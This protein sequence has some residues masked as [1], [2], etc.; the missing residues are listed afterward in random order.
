MYLGR[1]LPASLIVLSSFSPVAALA[2]TP[3]VAPAT[4]VVGA[5]PAPPTGSGPGTLA[6]LSLPSATTQVGHYGTAN[7]SSGNSFYVGY[8][9]ATHSIYTP[10]FAGITY[11]SNSSSLQITGSF[12]SIPGGR[13][14]RVASNRNVL[15][16]LAGNALAA[17]ALHTHKQLF[18][19]TVGG[20][21]LVTSPH[22][23]VAFVGGNMDSV[24]TAIDLRTGKILRTYNVGQVGDMVWANGQIFAADIQTGV[25]TALNPQTGAIVTI[26]TPEVDPNFSY[27]NI[28]AATAGFM[29]LAVGA[30]HTTVYAAGFSGHILRFSTT[31]DRYL[32]EVSVNA[33]P[34]STG[35]N[36]LSALAILPERNRALVTVENLGESVIVNLSTGSIMNT[37]HAFASNRWLVIPRHNR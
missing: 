6:S 36:K 3:S 17:Y 35:G 2:Q 31:R 10:A 7:T 25:M 20:N 15:L 18:M 28:P 9:R 12:P 5:F 24:I 37:F 11:I 14:A 8:S 32:G 19:D 16:V 30:H 23:R 4:A 1:S 21:A 27:S 22:G 13:I 29:Q 33:N 34:N 26:P